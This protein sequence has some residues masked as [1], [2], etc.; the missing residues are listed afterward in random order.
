VRFLLRFPISGNVPVDVF[1]PHPSIRR[2]E[3]A[4]L[5]SPFLLGRLVLGSNRN[6]PRIKL[7]AVNG[8]LR[9]AQFPAIKP[10]WT[11]WI[12]TIGLNRSISGLRK[13]VGT[14]Q[15]GPLPFRFRGLEARSGLAA[16]FERGERTPNFARDERIAFR[17]LT[18]R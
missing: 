13:L 6:E 2:C 1:A 3:A 7:E 14:L 10:A 18:N 9:I 16:V 4:F 12:G 17:R 8:A 11:G 5:G 15:L